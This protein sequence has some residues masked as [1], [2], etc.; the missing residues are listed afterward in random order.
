MGD[1]AYGTYEKV[2]P[3]LLSQRRPNK[4]RVAE[5]HRNRLSQFPTQ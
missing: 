3:L 2:A 5:I 4:R 1:I